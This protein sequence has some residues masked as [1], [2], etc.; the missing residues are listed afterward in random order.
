M[1]L[2]VGAGTPREF[3]ARGSARLLVLATADGGALIL[4]TVATASEAAVLAVSF[5]PEPHG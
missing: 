1:R 4:L 3:L 2:L 5:E